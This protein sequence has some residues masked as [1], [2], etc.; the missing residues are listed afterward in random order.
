[1]KGLARYEGPAADNRLAEWTGQAAKCGKMAVWRR[2]PCNAVTCGV[3]QGTSVKRKCRDQRQLHGRERKE[4][5]PRAGR[6]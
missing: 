4:T 2:M 1:V 5:R 6:S 3:R